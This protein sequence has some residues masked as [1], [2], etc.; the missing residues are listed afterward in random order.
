MERLAVAL[1]SN[2]D[3]HGITVGP[4]QHKLALYTDDLLL[5]L[6]DP[7]TSL[8]N[9]FREFEQF[10]HLSNFKVNYS[11]T[12]ALNISFDDA[13]V[14][15]LT[16]VFPSKWQDLSIKYLGTHITKNL[17]TLYKLNFLP[18][19]NRTL[20]DLCNYGARHLS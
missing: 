8:P 1:H 9:I 10:G 19:P 2:P 15:Y 12:E 7:H 4:K 14:K 5:Y 18:I 11:K 17:D 6:T 16:E 20:T 3:I 13:M